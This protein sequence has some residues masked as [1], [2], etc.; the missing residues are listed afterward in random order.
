MISLLLFVPTVYWIHLQAAEAAAGDRFL[1][2]LPFVVPPIVL[3]VGLLN[4]YRARRAGSTTSRTAFWS[5]PT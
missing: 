5:P 1:A 2:L 3:V 4:I